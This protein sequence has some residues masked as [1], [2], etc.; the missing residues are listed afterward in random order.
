M[1][2]TLRQALSDP[3]VSRTWRIRRR[4]AITR[5][6]PPPGLRSHIVVVATLISSPPDGPTASGQQ[7]KEGLLDF[8]G[9]HVGCVNGPG[10][11]IRATRRVP[12]G[13]RGCCSPS[14][15]VIMTGAD[16]PP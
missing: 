15:S 8:G 7:Q 14:V 6:I 2:A 4:C 16:L 11:H 9:C 10:L 3:R 12:R 1:I 5:E 13:C